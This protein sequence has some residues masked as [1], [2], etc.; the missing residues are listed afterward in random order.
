MW[1]H[2]EYPSPLDSRQ[3][4]GGRFVCVFG[5]DFLYGVCVIYE[6][7]WSLE[8]CG[9]LIVCRQPYRFWKAGTSTGTGFARPRT[10]CVFRTFPI[11]IFPRRMGGSL[12]RQT[13]PSFVSSSQIRREKIFLNASS[14]NA[15]VGNMKT[16][17]WGKGAFISNGFDYLIV[18]LP[19][20]KRNVGRLRF[21]ER[22]FGDFFRFSPR[23][24]ETFQRIY[25]KLLGGFYGGS[26]DRDTLLKDEKP[27]LDCH[28][29][30]VEGPFF[31]SGAQGNAK[32]N[33]PIFLSVILL[34]H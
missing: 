27:W 13:T 22:I 1:L 3:T 17:P 25:W 16:I 33:P 34:M 24:L 19:Q 32:K 12:G 18:M 31:F 23:N 7:A 11:R 21:F 5:A 9:G 14:P 20:S 6:L 10:R 30:A 28:Q 15:A 8:D 26:Q 2:T 29:P 4:C